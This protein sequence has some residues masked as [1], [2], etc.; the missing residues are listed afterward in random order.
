MKEREINL[1]DL[2]IEVLLHWRML[3]VWML[4][5]GLA[6]TFWGMRSKNEIKVDFRLPEKYQ[7]LSEKEIANVNWVI[8]CEETY[9]RKESYLK[10]SALMKMNPNQ[11]SKAEATIA[12]ETEDR[13]K[14]R[15]IEKVYEDIMQS[16]ELMARVAED[17]NIEIMGIDEMILL[18]RDNA[19]P[20][21][22]VRD[23]TNSI[24]SQMINVIDVSEDKNTFRII[25]KHDDEA[26]CKK[27]LETVIA[28]LKEKQPD[29]ESVL[30]EHEIAVVNESFAV[31]ADT[32][33][34]ELQKKNLIEL[35][36]LQETLSN[37]KNKLSDIEQQYYNFLMNG[38]ELTTTSDISIKYVLVGAALAAFFYAF[39]IF[40]IYIMNTKI[41]FT[42][43]LQELYDIPQLGMIPM[44]KSNKRLF[45]FI[46][47]KIISLRERNK[48]QFISEEALEL[49]SA[50]VKISA[51]KEALQ[52][53][54][55]IGCGLKERAF[56]VCE[57]IKEHLE[58][59][60]IQVKILNNVLY[61]ARMMEELENAKAVVLAESVGVT[62]YSEIAEELEL[63]KRQK[64]TVLGGILVE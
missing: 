7:Y 26:Q 21:I 4:I 33:I 16:G 37:A 34:G 30:G 50:A 3:I 10:K 19:E 31:V 44:E 56:E 51:G 24:I 58:R 9:R 29:I 36:E 47:E 60:G 59:N 14:S 32:N 11:V 25:V 61:D 42:D 64:I 49:A 52:E 41:R 1:I 8:A 18:N 17:A 12:I 27:M 43:G 54:F 38:T 13:Q 28:F 5:G 55:L 45:G 39:L 15:D 6:G 40:L 46:D 48:R 57:K 2:S 22:A 35:A 62:L 23:T 20:G 53:V 63:L